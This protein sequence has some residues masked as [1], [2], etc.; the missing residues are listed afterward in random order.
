VDFHNK[1]VL[2]TGGGT[3]IGK[4]A[5]QRFLDEGAKVVLN[6]RR[7]EILDKAAFELDPS[8]KRI[9]I[10]AGDVGLIETSKLM[11]AIALERFGGV[12]ILLNNAGIFKPT[13]FLDH[14]ESDFNSYINVMVRKTFFASQATIPE[15]Q[16][17]G[18]GVIVNTVPC[19]QFRRLERHHPVPTQLLRQGF[20]P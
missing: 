6:G 17:R 13:P 14:T 8:G 15:M 2:I 12:D 10:V 9:A 16:K 20:T 1:V 5:A 3:G 18:G 4:A 7:Q 19:G 11:V